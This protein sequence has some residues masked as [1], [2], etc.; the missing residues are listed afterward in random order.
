MPNIE[1]IRELVAKELDIADLPAEEQDKI[2]SRVGELV[3]KAVS[4]AIFSRLPVSIKPEFDKLQEAGDEEGLNKLV[5]SHIPDLDKVVGEA[6]KTTIDD[7][8]KIVASI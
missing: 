2:I 4:I 6:I 7:Y 3:V 1:Q 8:K 5:A